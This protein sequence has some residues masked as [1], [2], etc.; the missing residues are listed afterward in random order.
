[1]RA[2]CAV[3]KRHRFRRSTL[4]LS[5]SRKGGGTRASAFAGPEDAP[6]GSAPPCASR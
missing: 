4:T 6:P 5:L 1:M 3:G 2:A